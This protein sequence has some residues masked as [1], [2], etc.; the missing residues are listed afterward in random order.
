VTLTRYSIWVTVAV[1]APLAIL[2]GAR[3][4]ADPVFVRSAAVGAGLAG[5]NAI[6]AYGLV[7]WS[8]SRSTRA[9]MAAVLG[10]MLGRMALLL[11]AVA[12]GIGIFELQRLPLVMTLLA[13][14][15]LFLVVEMRILSRRPVAEAR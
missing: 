11:A 6:V 1:A 15:I 9:F 7:L 5:F 3:G 2:V 13:Y 8:Q 14:F 10:G 4:G 12:A